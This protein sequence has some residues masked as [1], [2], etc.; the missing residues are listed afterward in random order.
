MSEAYFAGLRIGL[1]LIA[2]IGVQNAFVLRQGLRREHVFL[3][4]AFCTVSDAILISIGVCGFTIVQKIIPQ[5]SEVLR[6][7]GIC[8]LIYYGARAAI[9]AWR[10][11]EAMTPGQGPAVSRRA[12][13]AILAAITWANPHVW[14]DTV[15][16]L[17]SVAAQFPG[18][19]VAFGS[20]AVTGS[21]LFFFSLAYGAR[22][23]APLFAR[24]IAWRFLDGGVA[25]M[26]WSVAVRLA[27]MNG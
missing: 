2:A 4:A 18:E 16:L 12:T 26:M 14:L 17:G 9:A 10:G 6:W 19:G 11:G 20:G 13:V 27:L 25:L 8:F 1:A 24:P 23:L 3:T 5:I 21:I 7:G 22:V 15:V